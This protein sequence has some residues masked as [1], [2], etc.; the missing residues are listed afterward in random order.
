MSDETVQAE[1]S[2]ESKLAEEGQESE[3]HAEASESTEETSEGASQEEAP[4][5][6]EWFVP[7][8]FRTPED[9][10]KSYSH[11]EAEYSRRGNELHKL[12]TLKDRPQVDPEREV[13]D[14]A[15][16]VKRNPVEAVRNIIK[17]ETREI[18]LETR[19]AVFNQEYN[20]LMA[21]KEFAELEPVMTSIAQ[22]YDEFLTEETRN[23]PRLLHMLFYA[24]KGVK[25]D[26]AARKATSVGKATGEKNAMKKMKA[27]V[28]GVSGTKG[29]RPLDVD[30]M[31]AAQMKEAFD[32]GRLKF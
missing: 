14:F 13:R 29:H 24:A 5:E 31:T 7:G 17:N 4:K 25:A 10:R 8:R 27:Q 23:D 12:R 9:M 15:D 19:Q 18:K 11:L 2:E 26:E 1:G 16:A 28:E 30:K 32:K 21:N 20:R 22:E 6:E 3:Q